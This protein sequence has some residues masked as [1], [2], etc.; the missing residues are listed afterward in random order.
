VDEA[1]DIDT[2]ALRRPPVEALLAGAW[3]RRVTLVVAG[4]GHGKTTELRGLAATAP[5]HWLGI[6]PV[7][8]EVELLATRI[9]HAL[10]LGAVPGLADPAAAI[11]AE[12]RQG[13]AEGQAAV[14]CEAL[15]RRD[16][17]LNAC[18]VARSDSFSASR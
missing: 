3:G 11:G 5:S 12:D 17:D 6:R 18:D 15:A 16:A 13:L 4:G 2:A 9:A 10:E 14:L 1:R 7:D 8:G